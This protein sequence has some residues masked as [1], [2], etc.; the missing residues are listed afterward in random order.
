METEPRRPTSTGSSWSAFQ[1]TG[2]HDDLMPSRVC[3][4]TVKQ[5]RP[6]CTYSSSSFTLSTQL[7][8]KRSRSMLKIDIFLVALHVPFT[9]FESFCF[10]CSRGISFDNH[11]RKPNVKSSSTHTNKKDALPWRAAHAKCA[12]DTLMDAP[13]ETA[14]RNQ[15]PY[16]QTKHHYTGPPPPPQVTEGCISRTV[17]HG[18]ARRD[19]ETNRCGEI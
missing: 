16:H 15:I 17:I 8:K 12:R 5:D 3:E 10:R 11:L 14:E 18:T 4:S 7:R 9:Y 1:K 2:R 19:N 6:N 13:V